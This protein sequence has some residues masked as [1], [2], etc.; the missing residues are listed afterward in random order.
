MTNSKEDAD[1]E[2]KHMYNEPVT[3][4]FHDVEA[5]QTHHRRGSIPL[6]DEKRKNCIHCAL[7]PTRVNGEDTF[8]MEDGIGD[9]DEGEVQNAEVKR[10]L[11][12]D[13]LV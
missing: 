9:E 10:E 1:I 4:L 3:T 5:S 2:E 8:S 12:K 13:I 11:S 7:S 6:K